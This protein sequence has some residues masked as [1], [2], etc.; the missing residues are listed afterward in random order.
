VT[1][2]AFPHRAVLATVVFSLA[3]LGGL[4]FAPSQWPAKAPN[5]LFYA[6]LVFNTFFS[7]RF[8]DSLPPR[9]RDERLIDAVLTILYV[10]LGAAIGSLAVFAA[11]STLLF[12]AAVAK[13]A[14]LQPVMPGRRGLLRR[15]MRIDAVGGLLC[16]LSLAGSLLGAPLPSAWLQAVLFAAANVYLLAIDPMYV[17]RP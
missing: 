9:D 2:A 10:A 3:G 11:L 16:V 12:A 1:V 5:A 7:V 15:K 6:V 13:Y 14:L 8:F 17:D 4:L